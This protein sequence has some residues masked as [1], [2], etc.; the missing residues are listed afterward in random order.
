ML[1]RGATLT[2]ARHRQR[3][4]KKRIFTR[5]PQIPQSTQTIINNFHENQHCHVPHREDWIYPQS[6]RSQPPWYHTNPYVSSLY[7]SHQINT[8]SYLSHQHIF[9]VVA[10]VTAAGTRQGISHNIH[11]ETSFIVISFWEYYCIHEKFY[12]PVFIIWYMHISSFDF[13]SSFFVHLHCEQAIVLS[14]KSPLFPCIQQHIQEEKC[15]GQVRFG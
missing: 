7:S 10:P 2:P 3:Q 8:R 5:K 14:F 13:H 11:K 1:L 6:S 15:V 4:P 9:V 12:T